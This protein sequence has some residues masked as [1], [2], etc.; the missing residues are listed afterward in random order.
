MEDKKIAETA[1]TKTKNPLMKT[2][3]GGEQNKHKCILPPVW[4]MFISVYLAHCLA[5]SLW[6]LFAILI[7]STMSQSEFLQYN[8]NILNKWMTYRFGQNS[9]FEI[10]QLVGSW[11][12]TQES[13]F[14]G[15][16]S[17]WGKRCANL[18]VFK[19]KNYLFVVIP[20][21]YIAYITIHNEQLNALLKTTLIVNFFEYPF[22]LIPL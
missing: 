20:E 8:A 7:D 5:M 2:C 9:E 19:K 10:W 16:T 1:K 22:I 18:M 15:E 21:C 6:I 11:N 14:Y 13:L 3:T 12:S 17:T 4:G